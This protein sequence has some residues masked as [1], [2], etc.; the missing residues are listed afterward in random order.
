MLT[1]AP[2]FT[3]IQTLPLF[4]HPRPFLFSIVDV[5]TLSRLDRRCP[6][7][8]SQKYPQLDDR[9]NS[10]R[11]PSH[12]CQRIPLSEPTI[13]YQSTPFSFQISDRPTLQPTESKLNLVML[14]H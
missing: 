11:I 10:L 1:L 7:L 4:S 13:Q 3:S 5:R 6:A 9:D 8:S 12:F 2:N 14:S